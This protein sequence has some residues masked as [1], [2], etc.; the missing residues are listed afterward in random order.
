MTTADAYPDDI[1]VLKAL[2]LERDAR[3]GHLE[4][5]VES[6]KAANATAKA[7]I[8]HLKLLIAKLRRMQFGRSSEKLDHQ[9]EQ[10][11]LRL[12]ELEADEGAAPIEVPKTPRTAPEQAPRKPLPEHL[13]RE[14][15]THWPESGE[16]CTACGSPMKLLGED[17][18]EQLEY[19]PASF[20]VIRHVR[21]KLACTCCDHIAQAAAPSRPIERGLAGP[22]LLAHVLVSK[23]ADHLPLYRQSVIYAREGVDLDRSLLA[24]WVGHTANLLQPL[25]DALRRHVMAATK[26]HADDTP[27]PVLAPGNGKT[28]TGRLWVYVRDDRNSGDMTPPAVWFA[29]TPDRR[30][31]HPQQHLASFSGT[32]QA[33]AYGG[34]QAIYE[35]GRVVEAACW[36]HARRLFYE[37]HAARPND[38]NTGALERIGALY[39]VEEAI[40]GKPPDERRA[41]RQTHAK[42]LLDQ[43]HAW[44]GATLETLSRKSD[45]SRA[46]LYALNRWSALTRYCDDGHLEIDNLPVERALRGVAIGR[47]N[48]LF[49]GADSG[50]ERAAAIY[51]LIGTAKL[52]NLDPEAYL[53]HVLAHIADHPITRVDELLPWVV[54]DLARALA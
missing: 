52:N 43:L 36:A 3:I 51:S 45:S 11:E 41:Y 54:A 16:T 29:Y 13:P 2:L 22:G 40:R 31:I 5:V 21:P 33:D 30:G 49:A 48:Y 47:R 53:R 17:V 23:F 7:E 25:V 34:Y 9:I 6:H 27:V 50:G 15:L 12:E 10:L 32:L 26:L 37:L 35:T 4:D 24:K 38:L 1:E 39:K 42:P 20:R 8:E 18:S 44:L 19:V 28:K 14:I 46:I